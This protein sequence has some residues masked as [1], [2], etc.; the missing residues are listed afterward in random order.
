MQSRGSRRTWTEIVSKTTES[1][2]QRL[3]WRL[4]LGKVSD[5]PGRRMSRRTSRWVGSGS[6]GPSRTEKWGIKFGPLDQ[7]VPAQITP[8]TAQSHQTPQPKITLAPPRLQMPSGPEMSGPNVA[9]LC[10]WPEPKGPKRSGSSW[11][12]TCDPNRPTRPEPVLVCGQG[13][14]GPNLGW[15]VGG[16]RVGLQ[17]NGRSTQR[18]QQSKHT[19]VD[20]H[21]DFMPDFVIW[22]GCHLFRH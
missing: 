1:T 9:S 19:I 3:R 2:G 6:M 8:P 15:S 4:G 21:L 20:H 5:P 12:P 13:V 10:L 16:P 17:C 22:V 14:V 11:R 18:R 7:T